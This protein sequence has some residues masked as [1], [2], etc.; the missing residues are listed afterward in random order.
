MRKYLYLIILLATIISCSEKKD[1][2]LGN[3][4]YVS[5]EPLRYFAEQIGG[6][7]FNVKSL[8]RHGS[9]PE[10]YE[11]TAEQIAELSKCCMYIKVGNLGFEQTWLKRIMKNAPHTIIYSA[12][13]G[14]SEVN[15]ANGIPDPH[16][17]MSTANA[18]I[19]AKNICRYM[20]AIDNADSTYFKKNLEVLLSRLETVDSEIRKHLDNNAT[21][22]F[23]IYHPALTYY[24]RDYMFRQLPIEEEGREP[25]A[26]QLQDIIKQGKK[27]GV[28]TVLVQQEFS[29]SNANIVAKGLGAEIKTIDPLAYQWDE[30]MIKIANILK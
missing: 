17:W 16:T 18:A 24:A 9:S 28:K 10:T 30:E 27:L 5:I 2:N 12:S 26:S 29:T 15:S 7:K 4:I 25:S 6:D 13:D 1:V 20:I 3:T 14:I 11:P 22:A 19:I 8:V 23:V 21:R